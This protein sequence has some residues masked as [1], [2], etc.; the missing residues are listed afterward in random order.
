[1]SQSHTRDVPATVSRQRDTC[2]PGKNTLLHSL[3]TSIAMVQVQ[4]IPDSDSDLSSKNIRLEKKLRARVLP[5]NL[6]KIDGKSIDID[7]RGFPANLQFTLGGKKGNVV[8]SSKIPTVL[9]SWRVVAVNGKHNLYGKALDLE[10]MSAR[11]KAR[12]FTITFSFGDVDEAEEEELER[13][14]LLAE[15]EDRRVLLAREEEA[16]ARL[17]A[18]R[19]AMNLKIEKEAVAKLK[20]E[21]EV[22]KEKAAKEKAEKEAAAQIKAEEV[23]ARLK[24]EQEAADKIKAEKEAAAKK[25]K[26]KE[27]AAA[28]LKAEQEA[29]AKKEATAKKLK[30]EKEAA[31]KLK[32]EKEAAAK[33]LKAEKDAVLKLKAEQ[34]AAAK[35]KAEQE[36]AA[37][38]LRAEEEAAAKLKA[39]KVAA[40]RLH[41]EKEVAAKLKAEQ[42][43]AAKIRAEKEAAA[44]KF[45]AEKEA[46]VKLKAEQEAAAKI[47]AEKEAAANKFKAEKEAAEKRKAEQ[48]AAAKLQAE[49]EVA[50]RLMA[51]QEAAAK[52]KAEEAAAKKV[53]KLK[54]DQ[55]A[56]RLKAEEEAAVKLRVE[57]AAAEAQMIQDKKQAVKI[58][59]SIKKI[60]NK[61]GLPNRDSIEDPTAALFSVMT[62]KKKRSKG[63][64]KAAEAALKSQGP[65][66]KCDGKHHE[67]AC[68]YFKNKSRSNHRDAVDMY[69][70]IKK[71]KS[72]G[73][74]NGDHDD[75][76]DDDDEPVIISAR[77]VN[78]TP[79]PGD[80]NC[81]FHSM[82]HGLKVTRGG[83]CTAASLRME[84]EDYIAAHPNEEI[85]DTPISDYILWDSQM[86][87][88][89]YTNKMRVGNDW[90][91]AIEI[92]VCATIKNVEVHV[93]EKKGNKFI[94][95][96]KFA[97]GGA[98]SGS[99]S[100]PPVVSVLY[101]GRCHYD[102]MTIRR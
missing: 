54:A 48:E 44:K 71:K 64:S 68:P 29:A 27:E 85:S 42:E 9:K 34:E 28:K 62:K 25:L 5:R 46:A 88:K 31:A 58:A 2:T 35:I 97:A 66:D 26:A 41:A 83:G 94:R 70:K 84:L 33:K 56:A 60:E 49:K 91:G 21:Q 38:K 67:S 3:S 75:D 50:A 10:I 45:K 1:M 53:A 39:E 40:A 100:A 32:A 77:Q 63:V 92:A 18:E 80:G 99:T 52:R 43:A 89:A 51:E 87:V 90:G 74:S 102:A 65:C 14:R 101:G 82:S 72:R 13:L 7:F 86:S 12:K 69:N 96:S 16:A 59:A 23:A 20:A 15:E 81:L 76:D 17:K 6:K 73:G 78:V 36:A 47:R 98:R 24:E 22:E 4:D 37:K 19:D 95:I 57:E 30:A 55:E 93:Y 8:T 79:Q 61:T 11:Q